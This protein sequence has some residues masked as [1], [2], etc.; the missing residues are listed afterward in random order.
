MVFHMEYHVV[1][2]ASI[3]ILFIVGFDKAMP[4]IFDEIIEEYEQERVTLTSAVMSIKLL[5]L[6]C[7]GKQIFVI[8]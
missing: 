5:I 6:F 8:K 3:S 2:G 7:I 1:L 4:I